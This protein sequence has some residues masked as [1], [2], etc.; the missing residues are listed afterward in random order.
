ML[1]YTVVFS[2]LKATPKYVVSL[3][4]SLSKGSNNIFDP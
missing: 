3:S 2:F 4:K 1:F